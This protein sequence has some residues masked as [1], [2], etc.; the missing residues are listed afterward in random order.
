MRAFKAFPVPGV[1]VDP[2]TAG[3][4]AASVDASASKGVQAGDHNAQV[5]IFSGDQ[6]QVEASSGRDAFAAG[7]DLTVN[8]QAAAAPVALAQL[9]PLEAGFTGREAELA[10]VAALLD[11]AAGAGAV[12]VSA[13]AGLAGVGKTALAV[14]A[15]HAAWV[16]GWFPGGVL[17]IDLHGYDEK[18]V[19]PGQALDALL[20]AL[21]VPGEHIPEGTEQRAGLYRSALAKVEGAVLVVAD[22]AS[23]EAQVR[24]LLPGL[25]PHRVIVTSRHTLAGLRARLLDVTVLDQAAAVGLLEKAVRAARPGDD[26]VSGDLVAAR[27]LAAACGGLPLALQV[28][29]ALLVADPALTAAELAAEMADEVGRLAALRYDDGGGAGAPSVAAAFELSYRQLDEDAARLFRLLPAAPGPDVSTGAAAELAGWPAGRA[30]AAVGRLVRAHLVESAGSPGRWRMHD[31]LRLYARQVLSISS[32]ER[33][34]AVGRLLTW[35]LRYAQ[36]AD[37]HLRALAGTPVPTEF[38]GRDDA[39]AWLDAERPGLIAAVMTAAA[40]GRHQE[41]MLL[42]LNLSEYLGWRR[43]FDDWLTVL[44]VSRDSARRLNDKGREAAA[45]T[46][47]GLALRQV[48]RFEEAVS[49]HQDAAI[50]FR[51]VGDRHGEGA[52]LNNLGAAL[53]GVRRFEEA[54]SALQDAAATFREVSDRHLEGVALNSL[55]ISLRYV[56]RFEEAV[57]AHQDAAIICREVGDRH[58]EGMA[59]TNLGLSLRCVRRFE[60]AIS[61]HQEAAV[62]YRETGDRHGEGM[63]LVG[64]GLA[65]AEA[66]RL[67]EAIAAHQD[68]VAIFRE[69]GDQYW[70]NNALNNLERYRADQAAAGKR[71]QR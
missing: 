6:P 61:A 7:R 68:A 69:T 67:E 31:L 60:E 13:V 41:A 23:S 32:E 20:R 38:T 29:A 30:R 39:L 70:E 34:E 54:V 27:R 66:R 57:S 24:P 3:E 44:A 9:P 40:I 18:P 50:L 19:Q 4:R 12:V 17:F 2:V 48:R 63:A 62:I 42:P 56:R 52:V 5:N 65:L 33:E 28:T 49:A 26:R 59:L 15:A 11:P 51:E 71:Q 8:N 36:A 10:R 64:L 16:S 21:G 14:H 35:Y 46:C 37:Q 47:L 58:G 43:R 53:V 1:R 55:G 25:G 45:L 22:N